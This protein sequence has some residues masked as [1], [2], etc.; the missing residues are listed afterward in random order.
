MLA[1]WTDAAAAR[2]IRC[3]VDGEGRVRMIHVGWPAIR[4]V[5]G[6]A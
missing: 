6:R 3:Q 5:E 1:V 2:G 4:R